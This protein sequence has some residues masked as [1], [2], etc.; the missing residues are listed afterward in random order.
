MLCAH[1]HRVAHMLLPQ[2]SLPFF[3]F[4]SGLTTNQA[5]CRSPSTDP[6]GYRLLPLEHADG[7]RHAAPSSAHWERLHSS[8]RLPCWGFS[9][10]SSLFSAHTNT[11]NPELDLSSSDGSSQ[12]NAWC[13][14]KGRA[15][16]T[17]GVC[18]EGLGKKPAA[19]LFCCSLLVPLDLL[20][21]PRCTTSILDWTPN[22][23]DT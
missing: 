5:L 9:E 10:T 17:T 1:S 20:P 12:E 15:I 11:L 19:E 13:E 7:Q 14:L 6:Y 8:F 3:F 2:T 4:P 23:S 16:Y 21:N 18:L 22:S